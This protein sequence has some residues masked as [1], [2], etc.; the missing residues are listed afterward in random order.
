MVNLQH[1]LSSLFTFS[2][3]WAAATMTVAAADYPARPIRFIVPSAPGNTGDIIARV[4][5]AELGKQMGQQIVID[6]RA[7]AAGLIGTEMIVRADAD[8]YTIGYAAAQNATIRIL[9]PKLPYDPVNDLQMVAQLVAGRHLLL[10]APSLPVKSIRE[11]IDHAKNNPGKLS[12]GSGG[13]GS[14]NHLSGELFKLMTGAQIVHVPYKGNQQVITDMIG[15]QVHLMFENLAS[16]LPHVKAGR[17]RTLGVSS[18]KRMPSMPELPTISETVPGF[19]VS[20]WSGIVLPL[21]VAKPI[22]TR[23][24]AEINKAVVSAAM[25]EKIGS[26]GFELIGGTAAQFDGFV[27]KEAVRWADI[28][29]RTGAKVD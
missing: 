24:N 1:V 15:G 17:V 13:N 25:K 29:K 14:S 23:L 11:L 8:G 7:G 27:K 26:L 2:L 21:G 9:H 12:Y 19:E 22:V 20:T 5:G 4:V 28:I 16:A 10:V 3:V 18:L 6:N